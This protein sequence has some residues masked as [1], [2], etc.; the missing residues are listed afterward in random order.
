MVMDCVEGHPLDKTTFLGCSEDRRHQFYTELIDM[1]AQLRQLDFS[2]AGSLMP[3]SC[4]M[5]P[6]VVGAF[7]IPINE[8]QVQGHSF[9]QQRIESSDKFLA[10]QLRVLWDTYLVPTSDLRRSTAELELFALHTIRTQNHIFQNR[11]QSERFVLSHTDLRCPNIMVDDELH[12]RGI[13][14][15][16]WSGTVPQQFFIPPTWIVNNDLNVFHKVLGSMKDKSISHS[17]LMREWSEVDDLALH[18][19]RI[20]REPLKML[21]VFY[22]SIYPTILNTPR[23]LVIAEFFRDEKQKEELEKRLRDSERYTNYLKDKKL[24]VVDEEAQR[25]REWIEKAQELL[26]R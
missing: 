3:A 21:T 18:Y 11:S 2:A 4:D 24:F 10:E 7:S 17:K 22:K 9:Q 14:D 26:A 8:L 13:I 20:L 6:T 25:M 23:E 19:I 15:W 16:E 5:T 1:L 12:I